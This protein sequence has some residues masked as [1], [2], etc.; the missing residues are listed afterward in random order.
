MN[1]LGYLEGSHH[2]V[3]LFGRLDCRSRRVS[4]NLVFI[5]STPTWHVCVLFPGKKTFSEF[6]NW[7]PFVAM[8]NCPCNYIFRLFKDGDFL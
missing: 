7:L 3:F 2:V 1:Q 5:C 6:C 8:E 4:G